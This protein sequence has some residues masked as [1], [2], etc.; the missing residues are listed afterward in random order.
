MHYGQVAV[1]GQRQLRTC[2][3]LWDE[4]LFYDGRAEALALRMGH[5]LPNDV[6]TCRIHSLCT[7]S[8]S[9]LSVEC[10]CLDQMRQAQA[11]IAHEGKGVIIALSQDG[12]GF[13][14]K[15]MIEAST[16]SRTHRISES[17]A[18]QALFGSVDN[19]SY[20]TA[21]SILRTLGIARVCLLTNNPEKTRALQSAGIVVESV[22]GIVVDES[23]G[24]T[25]LRASYA[26]KRTLGHML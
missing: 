19:R 16:Y 25:E 18:F 12:R 14:H 17:N 21:V 9:L 6:I 8:H 15:A 5:V 13:G 22:R 23:A 24:P 10:D 11:I 3:G 7:A 26:D 20:S 1:L 4:L 2:A